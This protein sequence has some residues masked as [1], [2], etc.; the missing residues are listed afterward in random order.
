VWDELAARAPRPSFDEAR[1]AALGRIGLA[2]G[3][4]ESA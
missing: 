1:A 3:P 2:A 4:P